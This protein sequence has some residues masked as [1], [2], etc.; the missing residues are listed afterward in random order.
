MDGERR[1]ESLKTEAQRLATRLLEIDS[2]LVR[3][4]GHNGFT[5]EL[6]VKLD[7]SHRKSPTRKPKE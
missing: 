7:G 6:K 3:L 1:I 4:C 2:E 5:T